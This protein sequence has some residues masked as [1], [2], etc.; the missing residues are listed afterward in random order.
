MRMEGYTV[1]EIADQLGCVARTV[2]RRLEAIRGIWAP[3][4]A[5]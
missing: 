5:P 3:E 2:E 1:L 4:T